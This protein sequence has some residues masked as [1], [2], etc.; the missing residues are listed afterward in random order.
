MLR[1][2]HSNTCFNNSL[3]VKTLGKAIFSLTFFISHLNLL[4]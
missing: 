3:I 1:Q 4:V 2:Y